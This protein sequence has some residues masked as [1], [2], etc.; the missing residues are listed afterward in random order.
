MLESILTSHDQVRTV[1]AKLEARIHSLHA[2]LLATTVLEPST[3]PIS[4]GIGNDIVDTNDSLISDSQATNMVTGDARVNIVDMPTTTR[5]TDS[6]VH[7]ANVDRAAINNHYLTLETAFRAIIVDLSDFGSVDTAN[8]PATHSLSLTIGND[9]LNGSSGS[10]I[11]VGDFS[12]SNSPIISTCLVQSV[13]ESS[14]QSCPRSFSAV[15]TES[16]TSLKVGA[17]VALAHS[18]SNYLDDLVHYLDNISHANSYL[19]LEEAL[20]ERHALIGN[21]GDHHLS[22]ASGRDTIN[23]GSSDDM[24]IGDSESFY[25][26]SVMSNTEELFRLFEIDST[27]PSIP[28]FEAILR[29]QFITTNTNRGLFEMSTSNS[30]EDNMSGQAGNDTIYGQFGN[31]IILGG[32]GTDALYGGSGIDSVESPENDIESKTNSTD[33]SNHL[34]RDDLTTLQQTDHNST[35]E[36]TRTQAVNLMLRRNQL[37]LNMEFNATTGQITRTNRS[38]KFIATDVNLDSLVSPIDAL[39]VVNYLNQTGSGALT[40]LNGHLN[41]NLDDA[42]TPID[43]LM[44][45]NHLNLR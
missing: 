13:I 38:T 2:D 3:I 22:L 12:L 41:T 23:G 19:R 44:I 11:L 42:V 20:S 28:R 15:N 25:H 43:A 35:Q 31:D 8:I 30:Q 18:I 21:R 4:V 5:F 27:D 36:Q 9:V 14:N 32:I 10:D 29:R 16:I 24:L 33:G 17:K 1:F 7:L 40:R 45:I 39:M 26:E 37:D 6:A 34:D